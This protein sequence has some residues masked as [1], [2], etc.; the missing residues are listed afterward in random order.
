MFGID[1][2]ALAMIGGSAISAAGGLASTALSGAM[3]SASN[4]ESYKYT[5]LLQE[6]AQNWNKAAMMEE[7]RYNSEEAQKAR[8]YQTKMSNTAFQ[9]AVA[10]L[11]AANLNPMLA[12]GQAASTPSGSTASIGSHSSSA[13]SVHANKADANGLATA[14]SSIGNMVAQVPQIKQNIAE[15]KSRESL[16]QASSAE[17][18]ARAQESISKAQLADAQAAKTRLEAAG[19]D[20]QTVRENA[21]YGNGLVG[22]SAKFVRTIKEGLGITN[23]SGLDSRLSDYQSAKSVDEA[24]SRVEKAVNHSKDSPRMRHE[25]SRYKPL[26]K[27]R[28]K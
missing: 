26:T 12:V 28:H 4:A 8:D 22:E 2:I 16:N 17:S 11:R 23:D 5:N 19:I 13:G 24:V 9:R 10:D 21:K 25:N 7:E 1:D 18:A 3:A 14:A 20:P 27:R 6:D 15:S